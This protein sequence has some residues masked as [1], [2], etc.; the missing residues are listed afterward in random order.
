MFSN[1]TFYHYR[2]PRTGN[3]FI[4]KTKGEIIDSIEH[5]K[6]R[7]NEI[8]K[9]SNIQFYMSLPL[10]E[11]GKNVSVEPVPGV[12]FGMNVNYFDIFKE[13]V[14]GME[15]AGSLHKLRLLLV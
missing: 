9:I 1:M 12:I 5:F 15:K 3:V 7:D 10:M 11:V 4:G 8:D 14:A 13:R 6:P 2:I